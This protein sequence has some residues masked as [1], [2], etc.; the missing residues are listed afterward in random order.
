[1]KTFFRALAATLSC[2]L[3]LTF[4]LWRYEA[5]PDLSAITDFIAATKDQ[6]QQ[7]TPIDKETLENTGNGQGSTRPVESEQTYSGYVADEL[8]PELLEAICAAYDELDT[9]VDLSGFEGLTAEKLKSAVSAVRYSRPEYFYVANGYNYT[10]LSGRD[11]IAEFQPEYLYEGEELMAKRLAYRQTVA[12]IAAKAPEG[13]DFDKLLYLHDYFVKNYTYDYTYTIRDA[14][15]FFEQKTGVC[16]AYMLALIATAEALEIRSIPVTSNAMNH[17]WNLV[18]LEGAWY[19]VDVTWDDAGSYPSYTSY[20]YFLQSDSGIYNY[21]ISRTDDMSKVHHEWEATEAASDSRYDGAAWRSA[22]APIPKLGDSYYCITSSEDSTDGMLMGG[23]DPLSMTEKKSVDGVWRLG[24]S[25][26]YYLGCYSGLVT[27]QG[28]LIYN[29]ESMIR[30][31]DPA[32]GKDRLVA[33]LHLA[34]GESAFGVLDVTSSGVLSFVVS[35][36]LHDEEYKIQTVNV[37]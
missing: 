27:Y 26:Q 25:A 10:V 2:L 33:I 31:Y 6:L 34:V 29:T 7:L 21:D 18:E 30:A 22:R 28:E 17:A 8:P 35:T 19:H 9:G 36:E 32:T 20:D 24:G 16:Q 23:S 12:N 37:T 15:T 5:F 13:S 3:L 1:M 4:C 11:Q 14:A